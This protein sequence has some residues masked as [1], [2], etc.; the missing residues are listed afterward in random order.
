MK[1]VVIITGPT[2]TGKT[3]AAV[4][5]AQMLGGEVVSADSAQIYR[6]MDIGTAKPTLEEQGGV[7]HHML[8]VVDPTEPFTVVDYVEQTREILAQLKEKDRWA[9]VCGGTGL[10][11]ESLF[12]ARDHGAPP[13]AEFRAEMNAFLG[14]NGAEAL[15]RLLQQKDPASAMA[16][17]YQD[18]RRVIRALE[19]FA[20]TSR[21]M[22]RRPVEPLPVPVFVLD[23]PQIELVP[24]LEKR[25]DRMLA[26]GL[27]DEVKGLVDKGVPWSSQALSAVGYRQWRGYFAGEAII[28][29]VREKIIIA[30]RQYAKRQ[31]TWIRGRL[32]GAVHLDAGVGAEAVAERVFDFIR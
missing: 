17:P 2:G 1:K 16:I 6:G 22:E 12:I 15:H 28:E 25:V 11:I 29:Q 3:A 7:P 19:I 18:T 13:N 14:K 30:T 27:E 10:Y 5:L 31:R 8:S 26:D 9:I 21:P 24:R 20:A 32:V 23:I 4:V